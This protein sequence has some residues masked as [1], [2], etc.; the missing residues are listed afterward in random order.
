MSVN[1]NEAP[2]SGIYWVVSSLL[3][4]GLIAE[5]VGSAGGS[6]GLPMNRS[7]WVAWRRRSRVSPVLARVPRGL[8]RPGRVPYQ[9]QRLHPSGAKHHI[10]HPEGEAPGQR[11]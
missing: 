5:P 6:G 11:L 1:L 3:V 2:S 7:G 4:G 9:A 8:P 10:L